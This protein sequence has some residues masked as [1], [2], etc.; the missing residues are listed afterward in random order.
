MT[1]QTKV[2]DTQ[3]KTAWEEKRDK[4][5]K[6]NKRTINK[7]AIRSPSQ[8]IIILNANGLTSPINKY[9]TAERIKKLDSTKCCLQRL[10]LDIRTYTEN[11]TMENICHANDNQKRGERATLHQIK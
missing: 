10:I 2:N 4:T 9:R 5:T 1:L 8:S 6:R 3:K 7:I 11:E